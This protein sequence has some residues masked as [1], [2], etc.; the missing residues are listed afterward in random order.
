MT[1]LQILQA[2]TLAKTIFF[3][4]YHFKHRFNKKFVLNWHHELIAEHLDKVF[5][6]EIKRLAI[7][8]APRYGKTE[9][10]V[11]NFIA[12][13]LA[14]N[15]ASKFI[16][17]SYSGDLALDN[18]EEIRDFIQE[19]E[20][21]RLYPWVEIDKASTAKKKWYTT[22][23]GGI[24]ATAT[25]GQITGF[26]AGE[27]DNFEDTEELENELN[28]LPEVFTKFAGAIVIDDPLK[29]DDADSDVKRERINERFENTIRS[30]TNSRNTP[31]II[32]GQAVHERDL[33]G[34]VMETEP[35]EWTLLTLPAIS[36]DED[37][38]DVALWEFKHTLKELY[39][40]R[41]NS[42]R[43]FDSQYMQ[44]PKDL[45]GL[46]LPIQ[47]LKF[48]F[49]NAIPS[50]SLCFVDP[51]DKG[52]DKLSAIFI[53]IYFD[54]SKLIAFVHDVV[55]NTDGIEAGSN[56]IIDRINEHAVDEIFIE[57]NGI[58]LALILEVKKKMNVNA[59]LTPI[60]ST[61]P[62]EVR[63]LSGFEAV[64]KYFIFDEKYKE[65]KEY[66]SYMTDLTKYK[67]DGQN[68]HKADAMDV[69]TFAA[70]MLKIRYRAV[71]Y[72][73]AK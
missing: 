13:G 73:G 70:N 71:L 22:A 39:K 5:S 43:T 27:M 51:A 33:I 8:I 41:D 16:H 9:L 4:R 17:L 54:N 31:I 7:R 23:G 21:K 64:E 63:I 56:R 15:P 57:S 58:G 40:L 66:I 69:T 38:N 14:Y 30:R 45:L 44:D 28:E 2:K 59:K 25:G 18:S 65:N 34:Y 35:D 68:L 47:K 62:K 67:R 1:E 10:A 60:T 42:V 19:T 24:Y 50:A 72:P 6:G 55:H 48:G 53:K 52:G 36:Q 32:I 11:K 49:F 37:G 12:K 61:D 20:F 46:L 3:T 26:G 29:P